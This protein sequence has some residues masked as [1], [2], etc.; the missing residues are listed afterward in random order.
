MW[1]LADGGT[2]TSLRWCPATK[3]AKLRGWWT[4]P[5]QLS[6][7]YF[8]TTTPQT[9]LIRISW[10]STYGFL[11]TTQG[12][13][14]KC[15]LGWANANNRGASGVRSLFRTIWC[16]AWMSRTTWKIWW[17]TWP[18][19]NPLT[20]YSSSKKLKVVNRPQP[21]IGH[22]PILPPCSDKVVVRGHGP[23]I[24]NPAKVILPIIQPSSKRPIRKAEHLVSKTLMRASSSYDNRCTQL[25]TWWAA[26][27]KVIIITYTPT[28]ITRR[29]DWP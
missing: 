6:K 19:F 29:Q 28:R 21:H 5:Q 14:L 27:T 2:S 26:S 18:S 9:L 16:S 25:L 17:K 4:N 1:K 24:A 7:N 15:P 22:L 8:K 13:C 3:S 23:E 11:R 10:I 12:S 20:P